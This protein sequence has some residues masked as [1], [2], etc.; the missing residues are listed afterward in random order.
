[1]LSSER[2]KILILE[3]DAEFGPLL[4]DTLEL[5]GFA[6]SLH[7]TASG[8]LAHIDEN[9]V[10]LVITDLLIRDGDNY[11]QDG[12]IKL[13]SE[14]KQIRSS[15]VPMIA[16]SGSFRNDQYFAMSTAMTVGADKTI[17]KPVEPKE[18]LRVI[19]SYI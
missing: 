3:D 12:G 10:D 9:P 11:V 17:A 8:A 7:V 13:I 5:E 19:R 18:L 4:K 1:M 16:I 14:L 2:K 6:V 15:S